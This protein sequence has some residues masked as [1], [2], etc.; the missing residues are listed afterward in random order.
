MDFQTQDKQKIRSNQSNSSR[1]RICTRPE[2]SP[3]TI[4]LPLGETV[5]H[6]IGLSPV[7]VATPCPLARSHTLHVRSYEAEIARVPS[8][9]TVTASRVEKRLAD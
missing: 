7:N 8:G 3:T 2:F 9:V 1:Q 5:Q 6:E 4:V